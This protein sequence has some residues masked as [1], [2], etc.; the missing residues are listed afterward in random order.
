[1]GTQTDTLA[2]LAMARMARVDAV[3]YDPRTGEEYA[4]VRVE[5]DSRCNGQAIP[6]GL[7]PAGQ[8]VHE[9]YENQLAGVE[10]LVEPVTEAELASVAADYEHH[11][12][13]CAGE[14]G[15]PENKR[16]YLPSFEASFRRLMHRDILPFRSV[17]VLPAR[18]RK[19]A[20]GG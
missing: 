13:E 3:P 5:I 10:A 15:E 14:L 20:S 8:S 18:K 19:A 6:G 4:L 9:I 1:M 17:S 16:T 11:C 12:R 2:R 7:V